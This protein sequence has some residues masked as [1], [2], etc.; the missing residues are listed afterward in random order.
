MSPISFIFLNGEFQKKQ[1]AI[2]TL[3]KEVEFRC[4]AQ[5][6]YLHF[7]KMFS[8][9]TPI[10][11]V[12]L[13]TKNYELKNKIIVEENCHVNFIEEYSS[14]IDKKYEASIDTEITLHPHAHFDFYKLQKEN[15]SSHHHANFSVIQQDESQLK[16]FLV[17][18]G[19][20]AANHHVNVK[21]AEKHASCE[22]HGLYLLENDQQRVEHRVLVDHVAPFGKSAM[23][24]KGVLNNDAEAQFTGRVKV[25]AGAKQSKAAQ[26]NH[27]LLLSKRA[28]A[29]SEPE[30]EIYADDIQCTHGATVGQIDPGAIFYLCSRGMDR[31]MAIDYLCKA[32]S[33]EVLN[34]IKLEPIREY[35]HREV[36]LHDES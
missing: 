34:K 31:Q 17:D 6:I 11:F 10:Q 35:M 5:S 28:T 33:T 30:L 25:H 15:R 29:K 2:A 12:F 21:L 16:M 24:Y 4:D 32:F 26:E 22:L 13:G 18:T 23:F 9:T 8:L 14:H 1:S 36:G 7:P 3:P 19:S 27:H 20:K